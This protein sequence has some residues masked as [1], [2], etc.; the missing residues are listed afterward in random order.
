DALNIASIS[1]VLRPLHTE[2]PRGPGGEAGPQGEVARPVD[3]LSSGAAVQTE[4][5]VLGGVVGLRQL[6]R[7]PHRQG[8]IAAQLANDDGHADVAGVQ[9]HVAPRVDGVSAAHR[10]IV[11]GGG[12][13]VCDGLVDPLVRTTL[14]GLEDDGDL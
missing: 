12:E 2:G 6:L 8:Q 7:D 14:V 11:E 13:A 3:A 10:S 4:L 5:Q 1:S 9:L